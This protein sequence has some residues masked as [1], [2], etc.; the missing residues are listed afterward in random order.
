MHGLA[1]AS[2]RRESEY[3]PILNEHRRRAPA[4]QSQSRG[5]GALLSRSPTCKPTAIFN[6]GFRFGLWVIPCDPRSANRKRPRAV[7][8]RRL[9]TRRTALQA[10]PEPFEPLGG[11]GLG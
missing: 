10:A 3:P 1:I 6:F 9:D 11:A 8:A 4:G 2:P 5:K 7:G